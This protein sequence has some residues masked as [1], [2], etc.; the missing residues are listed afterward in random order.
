MASL[1]TSRPVLVAGAASAASPPRSRSRARA[2]AVKVLEQAAQIGEIGAGIQL[3]P[4]AF[5]RFDALGIGEQR[6][7]SAVYTERI[8]MMDAVDESEVASIPVGDAFRERFGN[9]YAVSHR[10]DVHTAL[11]EGAQRDGHIELVT[12]DAR[13]SRR[14]GCF[15]RDGDRR[16]GTHASRR[17]AHRMRRGEVERAP[18]ARPAIRCASPATWSIAR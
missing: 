6:A 12:S 17:G 3:G 15:G 8:V 9:P 5:S 10:A 7:R 4:N 13:G 2:F 1:S 11:V 18:A 16:R 14:A